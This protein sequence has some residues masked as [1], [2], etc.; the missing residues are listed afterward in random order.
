VTVLP[1]GFGVDIDRSVRFFRGRSVMVGGHP[2]RVITLTSRGVSGLEALVAGGPAS[3][4]DRRLGGRLVDAGMAHPRPPAGGTCGDRSTVT[5]VVPARDRGQ[6]LDRCLASLDGSD[7]LDGPVPPAV[8]VVDDGSDDPVAVAAVCRRRGA[9]VV[10][11]PGNGGPAAARNTALGVVDTDLVAFVDSDCTVTAGWLAALLPHF[12]D[13]EVVAVAPRVLPEHPPAGARD[14]TLS[15]YRT[16]RSPLDMGPD[17][18]EVGPGRL[19]RYVPTAAMVARRSA[20]ERGFDIQLRVGE[21]VDLVWRLL[22]RGWRVRYEPAST[23]HHREPSTWSG[24]LSRR[25]RY[26]TSAGPLSARHPGRLA[27]IELR[28]WPTLAA[29]AA[30][31]GRPR[32]TAVATAT[33]AAVLF[34]RVRAYGLPPRLAVRWSVEGAAWTVVGL[35]RAATVLA[36]P[37]LLVGLGRGRRSAAACALLLLAPPATDWWRRRPALGPAHWLAASV[38]DDVA[39]GAGVWVGCLRARSFGPLVPA[40]H[41]E[42]PHRPSSA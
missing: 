23:V 31:A 36:S 13:P 29:V 27:P 17:R 24:L 2:G 37:L 30:L 21:D 32:M 9:R 1:A 14:T 28:P 3:D 11:R 34:R 33:G 19:V 38:S 16:A 8:V 18:G 26:G 5:I 22:D 12:A 40:L 15:R 35:G 39:Y 6:A 25:F 42:R 7:G 20:L 41:R 4:Q 10:R